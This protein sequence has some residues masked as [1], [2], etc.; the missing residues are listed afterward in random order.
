MTLIL[1]TQSMA[2]IDLS[3]LRYTQLAVAV[4]RMSPMALWSE[5]DVW[6]PR[7]R[8]AQRDLADA[9]NEQGWRDVYFSMMDDMVC[10]AWFPEWLQKINDP[11]RADKLSRPFRYMDQKTLK[12][13]VLKPPKPR[14][15]KGQSAFE[16]NQ[17]TFEDEMDVE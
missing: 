8:A 9:S 15:K 2:G 4:R 7:I 16:E 17:T 6:G 3:L 1:T 13:M 11:V 10:A 12:E 5:R 14:G